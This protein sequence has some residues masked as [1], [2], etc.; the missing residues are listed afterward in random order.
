MNSGRDWSAAELA[1]GSE[2]LDEEGNLVT[3]FRPEPV[4]DLE[5]W[6]AEGLELGK[7]SK[8]LKWEIGD[9]LVR[10]SEHIPDIGAER[11]GGC[12]IPASDAYSQA[13]ELTGLARSTL[14]DLASTSRR[15]NPSVRTDELTWSHHRVLVN[16]LPDANDE[17]LKNWLARAIDEQMSVAELKLAVKFVKE[18]ILDR[19]FLVTVPI[20]V[21]EA[22]KD[23]A[24]DDGG[25]VQ[26]IAAQWLSYHADRLE[27][28]VER[29]IA[30]QR[31]ADR[32]RQQKRKVGLKLA[33]QYSSLLEK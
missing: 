21:W 7:R 15:M 27:T 10:G 5:K 31:T 18:P 29:E 11:I 22:L 8:E 1:S 24:D 16:A 6:Q 9:W 25:T 30:K 26:E 23:F 33:S 32:R 14:K 2:W 19:S 28:S 3:P 13:H 4:F 17:T 12:Q 20:G